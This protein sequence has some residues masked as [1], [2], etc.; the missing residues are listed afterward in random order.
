[1]LAT[2]TS[3]FDSLGLLSPSVITYKLFLQGLWLDKFS[4]DDQLPTQLQTEWNQLLN[5]LSQL[6]H[7]KIPRKVLCANAINIQ[8][9]CANAINIQTDGFWGASEQAYGACLYVRS[10]NTNNQTFCKLLCS[11]SKVAQIKQL[12]IP[13][14]EICAAVLLARFFKRATRALNLAIHKTYLWSES[15]FVLTWIKGTPNKWK[16]FVG[17]RVSLIQEKTSSAHWKHVPSQDNPADLISRGTDPTTLSTSFWW[18]RPEWLLQDSSSWPA[19]EFT[20][21]TDNLEMKNVHVAPTP[22]EENIMQKFSK[23]NK[24]IRAIAY[25]Q[26]FTINCKQ[27]QANRQTLNLT[28][29]DLDRALTCMKIVQQTVY[30]QQIEYLM[31]HQEVSRKSSLK[32]LHPF[33]DQASIVRVGGR[34][35]NSSLSY[36]TLHP[37]ILPLNSHLTKLI[38]SAEHTR[39]HHAGPTLL[40]ASLREKYWIPR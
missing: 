33:I 24:L 5:V 14:L 30:A 7:I 37:V 2:T 35:Q 13:R 4:W 16:T 39:L 38:V 29:Q 21:P 23:L 11:S 20:T 40:I 22:I 34:L 32:T 25:C 15:S 28:P 6:S 36:Q 31:K 27:P 9:L 18:N 3:I 12:T 17:N 1:V 10:T 8:V 19:T 26:R